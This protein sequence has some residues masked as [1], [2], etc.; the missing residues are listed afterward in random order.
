[1]AN[2][3]NR[4]WIGLYSCRN[5]IKTTPLLCSSIR[6][7][8]PTL[9][10]SLS[11]KLTYLSCEIMIQWQNKSSAISLQVSC[12]YQMLWPSSCDYTNCT[13]QWGFHQTNITRHWFH[14]PTGMQ[15]WEHCNTFLLLFFT[16]HLYDVLAD[17]TWQ[18]PYLIA[19]FICNRMHNKKRDF[20]LQHTEHGLQKAHL[21]WKKITL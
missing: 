7:L 3:T 6:Y 1:M 5:V 14:C 9:G 8:F 15:I 12:F 4:Y 10:N 2:I 11:I 18:K 20:L 16:S 19:M 17:L 21:V 13:A